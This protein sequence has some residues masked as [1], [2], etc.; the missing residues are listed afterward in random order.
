MMRFTKITEDMQSALMQ[1]CMEQQAMNRYVNEENMENLI[2]SAFAVF[3]KISDAGL[4]VVPI[5]RYHLYAGAHFTDEI[6]PYSIKENG[7]LY[8]KIIHL[9]TFLIDSYLSD[10]EE[11]RS[12]VRGYDVVYDLDTQ[13][14]KLLYRIVTTDN[15][16]TT[17][18]RVDTD[19]YED[20]D[21]NEFMIDISSQIICK[22]K[23][24][25][26]ASVSTVATNVK[27]AA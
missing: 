4:P 20:F 16:L 21:V 26:S 22:L 1:F 27:E 7:V 15:S 3:N 19:L 24:S 13:Q 8:D 18:Y 9:G 5:Y 12:I 25:L 10:T 17:I 14:I 11:T 6:F 23:Q 2:E